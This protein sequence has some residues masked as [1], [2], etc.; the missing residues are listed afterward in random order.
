MYQCKIYFY[1]EIMQ[2][3]VL[4]LHSHRKR[5]QAKIQAKYEMHACNLEGSERENIIGVS[6]SYQFDETSKRMPDLFWFDQ[7]ECA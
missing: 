6:L 1:C 7:Y 5:S 2:F 3:F 4:M